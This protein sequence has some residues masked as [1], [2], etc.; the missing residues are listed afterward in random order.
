MWPA[1]YS[2]QA[3]MTDLRRG[4][5]AQLAFFAVLAVFHTWPLVLDLGGWSR[6]DN[7]DTSLN[8]WI[9]AWVAHRL[10]SAPL[11]LFNANI[12]FPEPRSLAF[13]EHMVVQGTM[14]MP[15]LKAGASP[16]LTYNVLVLTGFALSGTAMCRLIIS[17]TGSVSAGLIGGLAYAFNALT[18]IRFTNLQSLHVQFL[19]LALLTFHALMK[20][21][22]WRGALLLA[23]WCTLQALTSSYL[24][25]MTLVAMACASVA[26]PRAWMDENAARRARSV[27]IAVLLSGLALLP[28]LLPYYRARVEQGLIRTPGEVAF[29]S[30]AWRDYLATGGRLHYS[31]W[32]HRFFDGATPLFP[33]IAVAVAAALSLTSAGTWRDPRFRSAWLIAA[34]GVALSAGMSLPGYP[35]LYE[36]VTL[37]QGLRTPVR[38]G[39]LL[40]FA[41]PILAGAWLASIERRCPPRTGRVIALVFGLVVTAEAARVP[42]AYTRFDGFSPIYHHVAG[43]S[44]AVLL[45]LPFAP[46][47]ATQLN[48]PYVI[49]STQ[50]FHP[51]LNGYSGFIPASYARHYEMVRR[52]PSE[53]A[54]DA[55]AVVGV[56]HVV[57]H[58][59]RLDPD[60][61]GRLE[62]SAR[63]LLVAR[64]EGALLYALRT[65]GAN[66][67][68][69]QP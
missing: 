20:E 8:A 44:K 58:T 46:P 25:A 47:D 69:A 60:F 55:L 50:H 12:F 21:P 29:Y 34:A 18:L 56:T 42:M 2:D 6:L 61:V 17:W 43:L 3:H 27:A 41:L 36:H 65:A 23:L 38:F 45:E 32:S 1:R 62:R 10:P 53:A 14:G 40:L 57:A 64:E 31:A 16:I 68:A 13:S 4:R 51:L 49:A 5:L 9:V 30:G 15:L 33:G 26:S 37:L 11:D 28:F 48:S 22:R 24:L 59:E 7:A 19:P 67:A 35:W 63:L 39:W 66:S 54:F 52:L